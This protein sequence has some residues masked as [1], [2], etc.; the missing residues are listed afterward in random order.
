MLGSILLPSSLQSQ[1]QSHSHSQSTKPSSGT[2]RNTYTGTGAPNLPPRRNSL[3]TSRGNSLVT[4]LSTTL[5]TSLT[6]T[7]AAQTAPLQ[8]KSVTLSGGMDSRHYRSSSPRRA[9]NPARASTGTFADP[10]SSYDYSTYRPSSPRSSADRLSG[11]SSSHHHASPHS[12]SSY[13]SYVPS[14]STS[15]R[16]STAKY[17]S[18]GTRPRRNTEDRMSRPNVASLTSLP[19]R[20]PYSQDHRP[21]SPL[22]HSHPRT[23]ADTYITHGSS[24]QDTTSSHKKIYS[25]DSSHTAKLVAETDTLESPRHRDSG[26]GAVTSGR[27]SY[28]PSSTSTKPSTRH[29]HADLGDNGYSYTDP[30]S[31]YRDTEPAWRRPRAGSV[32][33]GSRPSSMIVDRP[34]RSS[35]RELG[36]PPSTRGFDK[37]NAGVPRHA[38]RSSSIERRD[39]YQDPY[40]SDSGPHRSSSTRHAPAVHQEPPREARRADTYDDYDRRGKEV[41][42]KRHS[43]VD[44]SF[45]DH[46]VA[47][48]GFGIATGNPSL[49]HDQY[50]LDRQPLY[51]PHETQRAPPVDHAP[52][53]YHPD[54]GSEARRSERPVSTYD[55]YDPPRTERPRTEHK[56][57][58]SRQDANPNRDSRAVPVAAGALAGMAAT[59][60]IAAA[61]GKAKER[62]REERESSEERE[63]QRRREYDERDRR[64]G[65]ERRDR[66]PEDRREPER[67][68]ALPPP[69]PPLQPAPPVAAPAYAMAQETGRPLSR[70]RPYPNEENPPPKPPRKTSPE[71]SD[72]ERPRHYAERDSDRS[73]K[74]PA[75]AASAI[76]PDEEY[77]RRIAQAEKEAEQSRRAAADRQDSDSDGGRERRRRHDRG[78]RERSR[79]RSRGRDERSRASPPSQAPS[80]Y[81]DRDLVVEPESLDKL[82]PDAPGKSV[83]IVVPRKDQSPPIKGILRKPTEKFPEDPEPIREGVAPHKDSLKGKDIPVGARWTRIDRKLVNPEALERAK[84]RFEERQDCVIVLRVL[85]KEE[86]QKL[87]DKTKQIREERE[88]EYERERRDRD[89][90]RHR[91]DKD[92]DDRDREYDRDYDR[93]GR[94]R[95]HDEESDYDEALRERER[96][97]D[98]PKMLEPAREK[99]RNKYGEDESSGRRGRGVLPDVDASRKHQH[100]RSAACDQL[101]DQFQHRSGQLDS[102]NDAPQPERHHRRRKSQHDGSRPRREQRHASDETHGQP[103]TKKKGAIRRVLDWL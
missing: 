8:L 24:R 74:E 27:S 10:Y 20:T 72:V 64:D 33:R 69:P 15:S 3:G 76:D 14:S 30:A 62:E 25:V 4:S 100:L 90:S 61:A 12:G 57:D 95:R 52:S 39:R 82:N 93:D 73:R 99:D 81:N 32:E 78:D 55:S 85:T 19:L 5:N 2:R 96:E 68:E 23:H 34:P 56:R 7:P 94:R 89:R 92:G 45:E 48:R 49:A 1:S 101:Y 29:A 54:R 75:P 87:A 86:I 98:R 47:S 80:R 84:E 22:T 88:E 31:M 102:A 28:H 26:Y 36:P 77:R 103:A 79:S 59:A 6:T 50:A 83:Q 38:G 9:Y 66:A 53:G 42:S 11:S 16:A 71:G 97:R 60:G 41:E 17:D 37:I 46:Q 67:R 21:S 44:R 51:A 91:K 43:T 35:T 65:R 70:D 40:A 13:A 18:Y 63:R 58:G